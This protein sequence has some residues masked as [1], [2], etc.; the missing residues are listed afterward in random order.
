M[1]TSR[2]KW[3]IVKTASVVLVLTIALVL[4]ST[5]QVAAQ[6]K[7]KA[8][9]GGYETTMVP[10]IEGGFE[11]GSLRIKGKGGRVKL[12]LRGVDPDAGTS[13]T[14]R[15]HQRWLNPRW[16]LHRAR[17]GSQRFRNANR[18]RTINNTALRHGRCWVIGL[19]APAES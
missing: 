12:D 5:S 8:V 15:P 11:R 16:K 6:A 14:L 4:G 17:T 18:S 19:C 7:V 13:G 1:T 10:G 3:Q 9:K 2:M